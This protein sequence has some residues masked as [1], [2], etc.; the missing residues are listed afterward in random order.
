[1]PSALLMLYDMKM[2]L[3]GRHVDPLFKKNVY[4]MLLSFLSCP[5]ELHDKALVLKNH[6]LQLRDTET[7]SWD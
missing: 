1:M 6:I 7:S 3:C 2:L 4:G 5:P